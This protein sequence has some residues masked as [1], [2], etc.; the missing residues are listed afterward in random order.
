MNAPKPARPDLPALEL[1]R[2]CGFLFL[3]QSGVELPP[4]SSGMVLRAY[5]LA[6]RCKEIEGPYDR[7][8][9]GDPI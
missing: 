9:K 3:G 4:H 1:E 6:V 2:A 5:M 7:D 8:W